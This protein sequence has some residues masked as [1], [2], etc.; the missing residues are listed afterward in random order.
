MRIGTTEEVS[1]HWRSSIIFG[2]QC[3]MLRFV[4]VR[5]A[6]KALHKLTE[7][8]DQQLGMIQNLSPAMATAPTSSGDRTRAS[9]SRSQS[10]KTRRVSESPRTFQ[11]MAAM[12]EG[13]VRPG[14]GEAAAST[15]HSAQRASIKSGANGL[16]RLRVLHRSN[17]LSDAE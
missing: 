15:S 9:P 4:H 14:T 5:R 11:N 10:A 2:A 16:A 12:S 3:Y 6:L 8:T 17:N 7:M 13:V 1:S